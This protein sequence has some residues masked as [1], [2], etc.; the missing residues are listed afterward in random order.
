MYF[1]PFDWSDLVVEGA[2]LSDG[3]HVKFE[4]GE[5]SM[6]CQHPEIEPGDKP[7]ETRCPTCGLLFWPT[8]VDGEP[9]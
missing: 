3:T 4:D 6:I 5:I 8:D 2:V 7:P 9:L 1:K